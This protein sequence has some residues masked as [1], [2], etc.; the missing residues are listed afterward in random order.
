VALQGPIPVDFGL[1][2]PDGVYAAGVFEPVRDSTRQRDQ[3]I[4]AGMGKESAA[5][6]KNKATGQSTST[7]GTAPK[8]SGTR[9]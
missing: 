5:A 9:P 4:A 2:F 8:R 3:K 1:V 6:K 7:T